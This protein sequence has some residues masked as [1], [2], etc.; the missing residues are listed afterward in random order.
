MPTKHTG[1]KVHI[2][3][4]R[5]MAVHGYGNT[6]TH[7]YTTHVQPSTPTYM[8]LYVSI[9]VYIMPIEPAYMH[10]DITAH[11]HA[12]PEQVHTVELSWYTPKPRDYYVP[13]RMHKPLNFV[14]THIVRVSNEK[15]RPNTKK[16]CMHT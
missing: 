3:T 2:H 16:A 7:S 8:C 14:H 9:C 1:S 12:T 6:D 10:I 4:D 13:L 15:S 5:H 11:R